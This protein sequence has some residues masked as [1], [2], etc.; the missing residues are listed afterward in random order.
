MTLRNVTGEMALEATQ[1]DVV[2]AVESSATAL[3]TAADAEAT[4][5]GGAIAVLK[6]LRTL[7]AG[8]LPAALGAGGGL[9]VDGSGTALP[10]SGTV[11]ANAGSGTM[12]V[13]GPL[14]DTQIRAAPLPVSGTVTANAG[15]GTMA[16]SGPLTDAQMRATSVPVSGSTGG[17]TARSSVEITRPANTTAYAARDAISSSTSAPAILEFTGCARVSAGSGYVVGARLQTDQAANVAAY[18]L[19]LYDATQTAINDN[20]AQTV[21][22]A[23]RV[24]YLGYL[25]FGAAGTDGSDTALAQSIDRP[26]PFVAAGTSLFGML[27]TLSAF[28]PASGQKFYLRLY[29]EQN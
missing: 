13:S 9:K 24:S 21:L 1:Q 26:F 12:A 25:D 28:T 11:T 10:V 20:S 27:E 17:Y 19:H 3:G 7:L 5:N 18:R 4:G 23:N 2:T 14:T 15:S 8:G 22:Y 6:R 29:V 16:V